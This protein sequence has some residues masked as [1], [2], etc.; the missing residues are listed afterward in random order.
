MTAWY[1]GSMLPSPGP[2]SRSR[3]SRG[4]SVPRW[5]P[6][7]SGASGPSENETDV[8]GFSRYELQT[9]AARIV[10]EWM[11]A[12]G[13]P[14]CEPKIPMKHVMMAQSDS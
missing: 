5:D 10:G 9:D 11:Q 12:G 8:G 3:A 13:Q 14:L 1:R 6:G 7:T 4:A 2:S